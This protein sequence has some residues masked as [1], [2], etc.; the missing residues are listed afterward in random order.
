MIPIKSFGKACGI[1]LISAILLSL[2]C[3]EE[4]IFVEISTSG[5]HG[6]CPVLEFKIR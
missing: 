6:S 5:C 2:T 3:N 4:K 1:L